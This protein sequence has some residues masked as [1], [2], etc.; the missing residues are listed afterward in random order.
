MAKKVVTLTFTGTISV[1]LE[2]LPGE[3]EDELIER[4]IAGIELDTFA[5]SSG[6]CDEMIG[7][8]SEFGAKNTTIEA[9]TESIEDGKVYECDEGE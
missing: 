2:T 7:V 1:E 9:A 4:V 5:S 6:S 8:H 3:D